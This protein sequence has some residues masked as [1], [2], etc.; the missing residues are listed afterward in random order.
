MSN[1]FKIIGIMSGTSL[2]GVDIAH[3]TFKKNKNW[4]YK[5]DKAKTV[6]YPS[7]LKKKLKSCFELS[8]YKLI[9]LD[10]NLGEFIGLEINKFI[11]DNDLNPEIIHLMVIQFF[12]TQKKK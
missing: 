4:T 6:E 5:I 9:K 10:H 11:K 1:N 7:R 2:D 12:T 8:G 3:C